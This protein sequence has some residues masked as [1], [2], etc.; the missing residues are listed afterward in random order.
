MLS[1][2]TREEK[3]KK[4]VLE[5]LGF[6]FIVWVVVFRVLILFWEFHHLALK[7]RVKS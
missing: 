6:E 1:G 2:A 3:K 5:E 4:D 7:Q